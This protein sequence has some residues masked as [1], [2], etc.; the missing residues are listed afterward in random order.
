MYIDGKITVKININIFSFFVRIYITR[1]ITIETTFKVLFFLLME[2]NKNSFTSNESFL[3]LT[4]SKKEQEA[5]KKY[6]EF[7]KAYS[8]MR[9]SEKNAI[10]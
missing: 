1:H 4:D 3:L 6:R 5:C 2:C 9:L 8:N 10:E 7:S